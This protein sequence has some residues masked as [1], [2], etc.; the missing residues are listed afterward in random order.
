[1]RFRKKADIKQTTIIRGERARTFPVG[2]R[3]PET[4]AAPDECKMSAGALH[5]AASSFLL[6]QLQKQRAKF[7]GMQCMKMQPG[8]KPVDE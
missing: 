3:F 8:L 4:P 1:M 6:E 2:F 5:D 7:T